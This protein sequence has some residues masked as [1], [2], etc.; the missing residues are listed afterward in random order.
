MKKLSRIFLASANPNKIQELQEMLSPLEIELRSTLDIEENVEVV[1]DL[2]TLEGNA[3]KKAKFWYQRTGIPSLSDDT[4]LEVEA[5][6]GEP[7]VY[8][9]R[10]AGPDATYEDNV[11]KLLEE[12]K[13]IENR[14]ARFRTVVAL[15][16]EKELLFE[17]VCEGEIILQPR[18]ERGFGYDPVFLPDGF[19]RTFAELN[20]EEKN[21]ISHR[22][23]A[24]QK[25]IG[26]LEDEPE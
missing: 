13:G 6:G 16:S 21:R 24:L 3:L 20:A 5:L 2:P 26:F 12:M 14:S 7:G 1:E 25:L 15:V 9:A 22:G 8:S 19:N 4:G 17:G 11:L 23:R 10:Y 18:G